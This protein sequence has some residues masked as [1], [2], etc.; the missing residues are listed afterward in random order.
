MYVIYDLWDEEKRI[1]KI[2]AIL[3][4]PHEQQLVEHGVE[5]EE[6][7]LPESHESMIPVLFIYL[8]TKEMYYQYWP[9]P[10]KP[11]TLPETIEALQKD[12]ADLNLTVGNIILESANDKATIASLEETVGTLLFE[13][14]AL[15][16]GAE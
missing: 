6:I 11:P 5:V 13:V 2:R 14:A 1:G 4:H 8:D 16:G 12:N 7:P 15:K 3:E 9:E 10:E